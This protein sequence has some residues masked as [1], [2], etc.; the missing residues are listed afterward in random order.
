MCILKAPTSVISADTFTADLDVKCHPFPEW[1]TPLGDGTSRHI[2]G[3][4]RHLR[5]T[6]RS[7]GFQRST[8]IY[9]EII[10]PP[11]LLARFENSWVYKEDWE[12]E[13]Y[14]IENLC[15][16]Q[17]IFAFSCI[18]VQEAVIRDTKPSVR[19]T[20]LWLYGAPFFSFYKLLID[21]QALSNL[22]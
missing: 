16:S 1:N 22:T 18:C 17:G 4:H 2:W 14:H 15:R 3:S 7:K 20:G 13:I 5:P 21:C 19:S 11:S 12:A 6:F 9:S 8:V 10:W